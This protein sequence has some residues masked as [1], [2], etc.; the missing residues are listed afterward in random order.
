MVQDLRGGN[1]MANTVRTWGPILGTAQTGWIT[2]EIGQEVT[3]YKCGLGCTCFGEKAR[4]ERTTKNHMIFVT[5][6]GAT[7]KTKVDN[8]FVTVGK[9][10]SAGYAVGL[11]K[12]DEWTSNIIHQKVMFWN[13][14]KCCFE[15]K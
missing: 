11:R 14:K 9:A 12:F 3:V 4:L 1:I 7:V 2:L 5:E 13:D 10:G 15:N 8:I 6:S